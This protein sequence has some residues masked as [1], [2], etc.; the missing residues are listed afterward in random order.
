MKDSGWNSDNFKLCTC[1]DNR[2]NFQPQGDFCPHCGTRLTFQHCTACNGTG[3][4]KCFKCQ[5]IIPRGCMMCNGTGFAA[6]HNC[7]SFPNQGVKRPEPVVTN[8]NDLRSR[9]PWEPIV[10]LG[11]LGVPQRTKCLVC[12]GT[13]KSSW[14]SIGT[15]IDCSACQGTGWVAS[16]ISTSVVNGIGGKSE[17]GG[18]IWVVGGLI[19]LGLVFA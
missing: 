12:N 10:N 5:G 4:G 3:N 11:D 1:K 7:Q 17:D 15:P 14:P 18:W 19:L 9:K 13:G 2:P 16:P 8:I 6:I